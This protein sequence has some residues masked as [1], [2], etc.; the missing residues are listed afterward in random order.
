MKLYLWIVGLA[1]LAVAGLAVW[2]SFSD[3][4]FIAG[5][6]SIAMAAILPVLLKRKSPEREKAWRDAGK[7]GEEWDG[8]RDRPRDRR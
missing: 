5:L 7:R 6:V 8:F 1:L 2:F 3:P 4:R